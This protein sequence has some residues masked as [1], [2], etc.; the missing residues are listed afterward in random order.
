[1]RRRARSQKGRAIAWYDPAW[2]QSPGWNRSPVGLISLGVIASVVAERLRAFGVRVI[3]HD[4][5][6]N[7]DVD[8]FL[9]KELF[10]EADVDK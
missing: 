8:I 4:P 6:S 1:L 3:T 5:Y 7:S 10:R 2:H 9:L